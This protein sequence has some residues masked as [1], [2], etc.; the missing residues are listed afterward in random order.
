MGFGQ[1]NMN[2]A[3][4]NFFGQHLLAIRKDQNINP[5]DRIKYIEQLWQNL[6]DAEKSKYSNKQHKQLFISSYY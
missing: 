2:S 3:F 6:N 5:Q 4:R 1:I